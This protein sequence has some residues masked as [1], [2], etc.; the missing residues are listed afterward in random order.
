MIAFKIKNFIPQFEKKMSSPPPALVNNNNRPKTASTPTKLVQQ[1]KPSPT[2]TTNNNTKKTTN[3]N[4]A[5]PQHSRSPPKFS[6]EVAAKFDANI[7]DF[8]NPSSHRR[9]PKS[10]LR[11]G[12]SI[13]VVNKPDENT[14]GGRPPRNL[15]NRRGFD[16]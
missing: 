7:R 4:F 2:S 10:F 16:D 13:I 12:G 5:F 15:A 11:K 3:Y 9:S 14:N 1:G 8:K 6:A